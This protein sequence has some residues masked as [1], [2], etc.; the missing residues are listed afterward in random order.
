MAFTR[1]SFPT[2]DGTSGHSSALKQK[3]SGPQDTKEN[4]EVMK[5][6]VKERNEPRKITYPEVPKGQKEFREV[7]YVKVE[8]PLEQKKKKDGDEFG[9]IKEGEYPNLVEE[10]S[11]VQK[12]DKGLFTTGTETEGSRHFLGPHSVSDT[13]RYPQGFS[14][15]QGEVKEGDYLDETTHEAWHGVDVDGDYD[16]Y[17]GAP[18]TGKRKTYNPKTKKYEDYKK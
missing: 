12:D 7:K 18:A 3:N 13:T 4:R 10:I 5:R 14:D 1:K 16:P 15:W 17:K 9:K 11:K 2:I 6:L 8:S